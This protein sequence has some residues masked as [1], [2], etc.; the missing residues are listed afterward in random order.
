MSKKTG[1]E[2]A[3]IGVAG[4]FPEAENVSQYWENLIAGK[5]SIRTF[6]PEEAQE[7]GEDISVVN[8]PNY[9]RANAYVD[10]KEFFDSGLFGYLPDEAELM[11]PQVR[12]YHECCWEAL[13]TAGYNPVNT[14]I[15][16][17]IFSAGTPNPRWMI[18]SARENQ[19]QLIDEFTAAHLRD[20]S[21]LSSR[22]AYKLNL[23][24]PAIYLQSACSS[25]LTA[26]HEACSSLLLGE[27]KM[28]L[29]GG[30]SIQSFSKKGYL[31]QE[32]MIQSKDGK[33]RPFDAH[34][35][36]T[37]AGEGVGV[38]VLRRLKDAIE[39]GDTIHAVIKGSAVNNDGSN[40][41][42]YTAP[43][44]K[45]QSEVIS[46][47]LRMAQLKPENIGYVEAH[48]TATELGDPIEVEALNK[49]YG[50]SI[51]ECAL[52]SVKSN[53][54]HLDA[55]AG[56]AGF[57][58]A[59][60]SVKNRTLPATLHFEANNPKVDFA[61]GPFYVNN[62]LQ[63][64]NKEETLRIGVSSFGIGGT[65]AHVIVEE[66]PIQELAKENTGFKNLE[67]SSRTQEGLE[68]LTTNLG[69]FLTKNGSLNLDEVA[70]TLR[71]GRNRFNYRR[72][73]TVAS[74]Q[75]AIKKLQEK[76]YKDHVNTSVQEELKQVAFA[77]SGQGSQYFGM[78][79]DLYNNDSKF[80]ELLDTCFLIAQKY[81]A[82]P[83]QEVLFEDN[84]GKLNETQYTQPLLYIVEF[85][86]AKRL[87]EEGIQPQ[88]L[89]GHSIGEFVAACISGVFS[90]EDGLR[91]VLK[92]GELMASVE[93]GKMLNVELAADK[94][95][96]FLTDLEL[97]I[98][99]I[100]SQKA[101]V[102]AGSAIEIKK[103]TQK[104]EQEGVAHQDVR[105]SHAFHS[106]MMDGILEA[107]KEEVKKVTLNV[108]NI[109][110]ISN[111]SGKFIKPEEAQSPEYWCKHLRS[112]VLFA[113][114]IS[115]LMKQGQMCFI[116]VGPGR[117][118]TN[119]IKANV[120]Y[121]D[122][123]NAVNCVRHP[124]QEV[125]DDYFWAEKMGQLWLYGLNPKQRSHGQKT[126][127]IPLPTYVFEKKEYTTNFN[128]N[129]ILDGSGNSSSWQDNGA[130]SYVNKSG[131]KIAEKP[132]EAD[133]SNASVLVFQSDTTDGA[134]IISYLKA[135][136]AHV[137]SVLQGEQFQKVSDEN[138]EVNFLDD[139]SILEFWNA[140][141]N[142]FREEIKVI[143]LDSSI[144]GDINFESMEEGLNSYLSVANI[145]KSYILSAQNKQVD[146]LVVCHEVVSVL[147]MDQTNPVKA[148]VLG[149]TKVIPSES[150][151]IKIKL[152]DLP[153]EDEKSSVEKYGQQ[154]IDELT[155]SDDVPIVAYRFG[156]KWIQYFEQLEVE[157]EVNSQIEIKENGWYIVTGGF[158][159]MG[160]SIAKDLA[161][162][163]RANLILVHRS[164]FPQED[165]W[166]EYLKENNDK[167]AEKIK[168]LQLIKQSGCEVELHQM[169]VSNEVHVSEFATKATAN[170]VINGL[171]WAAGEP[172]ND[173]ILITRSQPE[174]TKNLKSKVHGVLLFQ[175]HFDFG[176]M[177]FVSLFSSIGNVFYQHKFGQI[178]YNASNEFME[179]Y[180]AYLKKSHSNHVF[181]INWCDWLNVGMTYNIKR[182]QLSGA[183]DDSINATIKGAV[184]PEQGVE[185]FRT[186]L[187]YKPTHWSIHKGDLNQ[188]IEWYKSD[189]KKVHAGE[190][191]SNASE[192]VDFNLE[193]SVLEVIQKF[194]GDT[195][196]SEKDDFFE[197]GGDSLKAMTLV[198]RL[199]K[200][201]NAQLSIKDVYEKPNIGQLVQL[202][203]ENVGSGNQLTKANAAD[204]YPISY[205]Q[206]GLFFLQSLSP[207]SI[208]YN[209]P[210]AFEVG[211]E[212]DF[213]KAEEAF[214]KLLKRHESLRTI[215][216]F[217]DGN[218][219]LQV[220]ESIE[221]ELQKIETNPENRNE[222]INDFIQPFD[223]EQAP[224]FRAGIIS[225]GSSNVLIFDSHHIVMD[226]KSK[227]VLIDEFQRL[228]NGEELPALEFQYKD[229]A[230]W[231]ETILQGEKGDNDKN[232]WLNHFKGFDGQ[233]ELP[234][235]HHRPDVQSDQGAILTL[236]LSEESTYFLRRLASENGTT[237]F[238]VLIGLLGIQLSKY[239]KSEDVVIG[240]PTAGRNDAG[241]EN[242]IGMFVSVLALR[243]APKKAFTFNEYIQEVAATSLECFDHQNYPF[244][245]LVDDLGIERDTKR[246]PLFDVLFVYERISSEQL[247]KNLNWNEVNAFEGLSRNDIAISAVEYDTKIELNLVYAKALFEEDTISRFVSAIDHLIQY[248]E[249]HP[250]A[251]IQD[252]QI[253][254]DEEF[255]MLKYD[256]NATE[257]EII[258]ESIISLFYKQAEKNP[259]QTLFV[260]GNEEVTYGEAIRMIDN[261][262]Y[263][264]SEK[265]GVDHPKVGLLFQASIDML[266]GML[267]V[268][269]AGGLYIP[270]S[271]DFPA[272]RNEYILN[273]SGADV[274][275]VQSHLS[276]YLEENDINF[277]AKKVLVCELET[278]EDV[279]PKN[280]MPT[281]E[282]GAYIIY[283]SG[284][285]GNPKG[286]EVNHLGL[287]NYAQWKSAEHNVQ[288][289]DTTLQFVSYYFDGF[290][291]AYAPSVVSGGAMVLLPEPDK[292]RVDV[293]ADIILRYKV[294]HFSILPAI[295]STLLTE[296]SKLKE[297]ISHLKAVTLA[298]EKANPSL[299]K[300]SKEILPEV[301]I[302]NEYGPTE[303][304][305][306]ITYNSDLEENTSIIGAPI[307]NTKIYI[308]GKDMRI[309]PTGIAGELYVGGKGLSNGYVNNEVLTEEKFIA[310]PF[311][312][313]ERLY[314]TGDLARWLSDGTIEY[315]GR[316]DHQVKLRG[317]R[318]ELGEIESR[319]SEFGSI[320]ESAVLLQRDGDHS[321]LVGYY[322]SEES[323]SDA[324]L[325]AHL[326]SRLPEYMVPSHFMHLT[327][328][329]LTT[330]G[331]LNRKA[332]PGV[333]IETKTE[334]VAPQTAEQE[335]LCSIW[336]SVLNI[337]RVG[338]TDN[339]F[340]I[341]GD[342]IKS[343]QISSRLRDQGYQLS[344]KD[345][346]THQTVV[347]L[348][349]QLE[350]LTRTIDQGTIEGEVSLSPIQ[351]WF[352]D[353]S[354]A[355]KSHFN[356]SVGLHFAEG[357]D[358]E[359]LEFIFT[360]LQTHHDALRM[361]YRS[362]G[363][364]IVQE[365][366]GVEAKLH[367]EEHDVRNS[368][369]EEYQSLVDQL[370]E[371]IDLENGPL[372]RI[373]LF[374]GTS[375]SDVLIVIHHLVIDGVSWRILFEDIQTLYQQHQSGEQAQLPLKT[376][377]FKTWVES[378][379]SYKNEG[380]DQ[381]TV[382]Y[383]NE[384]QNSNVP[385]LPND[386]SEGENTFGNAKKLSFELSQ[387]DTKRLLSNVH[388]A[389]GTQVNDLLLSALA[390]GLKETFG[391]E[392][393]VV[394]LEGHG[395]ENFG[396]NLDV[397]RTVG[398]F[399]SIYPVILNA[400][401][402]DFT[403]VTRQQKEQLR[404]IPKNGFDYLLLRSKEEITPQISF[405][406]LGQF[407]DEVQNDQFSL[408]EQYKGFDI[409]PKANRIYDLDLGG[410]VNQG[411]F[412]MGLSYSPE[413]YEDSRMEVL[414]ASLKRNLIAIMDHCEKQSQPL[415]SP[416]DLTYSS[417]SFESLDALQSEYALE[418]IY[419][420]SPMQEGMLF[421]SLYDNTSRDNFLQMIYSIE[422]AM[423]L[424][425][426]ENSMNRLMDRY[427]VLRTV[428]L[429][430][431]FAE[432]LQM[433]LKDRKVDY[434]YYDVRSEVAQGDEKALLADY[435]ERD[436]N[437]TFDLSKDVMMR[438]TILQTGATSYYFIWSC[439]HILMDGWCM[440]IIIS[441]FNSLYRAYVN[442]REVTLPETQPYATYIEWLSNQDVE[443]SDAFW[444]DY[445]S[446][447]DQLS[448]FPGTD[449]GS[450]D[451]D[452]QFHT[453]ELSEELT[454]SLT[455]YGRE[456]HVT[457]NTL[458]QAAWGVLLSSY[459]GRKDVAF[460][461]VVSGRPSEVAGIEQMVGLFINTVP[462]RV[463]CEGTATLDE[464]LARVQSEALEAEA[465]HSHPLSEIQSHSPLG[466]DL[467]DHIM[468]V[469]NYPVPENDEFENDKG[470]FTADTVDVHEKNQFNLTIFIYPED[471]LKM[472]FVY[473]ASYYSS[474]YIARLSE[475][476]DRIFG[477]FVH[478]SGT[479]LSSLPLVSEEDR[480]SLRAFIDNS[481]AQALSNNSLRAS[482]HQERMWFIDRFE[483]GY[484]YDA[485]PIY[486]NVPLT[487]DFTGSLNVEALQTSLQFV[488]DSYPILRTHLV[489]RE[490]RPY[491]EVLPLELSL[492]VAK[493]EQ[494][495]ERLFID[496][497]F[498]L[499][500]ALIR[501]AVYRKSE[502]NHRFVL[503]I[504]H[505]LVD[506]PSMQMIE[507][508]LLSNYDRL[509]QGKECEAIQGSYSYWD[510]S[511]WQQNAFQDLEFDY[512]N[513]WRD[514][515]GKLKAL[516]IPT[517]RTREAI[518]IYDG[519]EQ[520]FTL[521]ED[522]HAR[523]SSYCE[524]SGLSKEV[525]LMSA[526]KVL[527]YKYA[528]HSEIVIGTSA[529]NRLENE[530]HLLGPVS[531]LVVVK[532][533]LD[534]D[535]TFSRYSEQLSQEYTQDK[536]YHM[537][538]FDKLVKELAPEKDMSRTALFDI[539]YQYEELSCLGYD[540]G[541]LE[542]QVS[543]TNMGYGKYDL[544]LLM[545]SSD[546]ELKGYLVFN[547]DYFDASTISRFVSHYQ[548][549]LSNVLTSP[550]QRLGDIGPLSTEDIAEVH[551][552][553]NHES[554]EYPT[555][556]TLLDLFSEQVA[557]TPDHI[558]LQ[559]N[560]EQLS[561]ADLDRRS[562]AIGA[563]LQDRGVEADTI[564]G[565]LTD[566]TLDTVVCMLGILKAGGAYL[567]IDVDYPEDRKRYI[568]TD[569][570]T[571]FVLTGKEV[572]T[573]VV[574][575]GVQC[576]YIEDIS[577]E[578]S[579]NYTTPEVGPSNLCYIIYTSGT[580]GKPKGVMIEH[581]NVVRLF[582]NESFQFEFGSDDV[583]TM[584]HSHCFDFSV[585]EMYGAL[586]FGGK[587]I[588]VPKW[589][590]RDT[591][592]YVSLLKDEG[593]TVLNQTPSAFYNLIQQEESLSGDLSLRYVIFGGEAL[594]PGKLSE[595]HAVYPSV[596]LI[597]M[598]GITETTVHVTYKK[599]TSEDIERNVSNIGLPIPTLSMYVLDGELNEVPRGVVGEMYIGGRGV[600]RG[601]LNRPELSAE[602]FIES[603][604]VKGERLYKSGDLGRLNSAGEL[605][606]IGRIDHQVQLR[607]F[608]IELGEIENQLSAHDMVDQ[609]AVT[610]Q[611]SEED[612]NLVA[613]YVSDTPIESMTLRSHLL[614]LL[615]DYM[616]PSIY[617]HLD[618]L[619][620]TPNG[621]TDKKAL[622][623][624]QVNTG[625]NHVEAETDIQRTLVEIWSSV[626]SLEPE[627]I[628]I[629]SNF[630]E[631]GG[632]SLN[633]I[634]LKNEI[635]DR[636][637]IEIAIADMFRL[638]TI[639]SIEEFLAG[640]EN[641]IEEMSK[642]IDASQDEA[643]ENLSLITDLFE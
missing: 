1:L 410:I 442:D 20:V 242:V 107:F 225:D 253:I 23:N 500:D 215:F 341:G 379:E 607:G 385:R 246:N 252:L 506:R 466:R 363:G 55:A 482:Y 136:G 177:E 84:S 234:I 367:L 115:E 418:N 520:T 74:I 446:G 491:Q 130:K 5:N 27:C 396:I 121:S 122:Q 348:S 314:R 508:L 526:F 369:S 395:R 61:G 257:N 522:L 241:L 318:I 502:N 621:K 229:F 65:N 568:I 269:R 295:Y 22:M 4:R 264:L 420:L 274:L 489:N 524:A 589:Q 18:H 497:A 620:L 305:V 519:G 358:R 456:R 512:V 304:T 351:E 611:G 330:N 139:S 223:L 285:T 299:I 293:M 207:E 57:I 303:A 604:F 457:L 2:I 521:S 338:I 642:E 434:R 214:R 628:G 630:F 99:V 243:L 557:K 191:N 413:R 641:T 245:M 10:G 484:L 158:G 360:E 159:G 608:R 553:L 235:D 374:H 476:L 138:F 334:Y 157:N 447:Y 537:M 81:T 262:A 433:V 211:H 216:Q 161:M 272:D 302:G 265:A 399:T 566:R 639:A 439:H 104:L 481:G 511:Y 377:A 165:Q 247:E 108:P 151:E 286:V 510:Y 193:E 472:K 98:A 488:I 67:L 180:A 353:G 92:R 70:Y 469:E 7:E 289:G 199:N 88:Y 15:K 564:V 594:S 131:W 548:V 113:D 46:R 593:V 266:I 310:S 300:R 329:P 382:E 95:Q 224:L 435:K 569:S 401:S 551:T 386:F 394:D 40:K 319:L 462:V 609:S 281:V 196:I 629:N 409:S 332:L 35:S 550:D 94:T 432:P 345:I 48:G 152:M 284:T 125:L 129:R 112:T 616:V 496:K 238:N 255:K 24:G 328:L 32:G 91:L 105:T 220:H 178:G 80:K 181:S 101:T 600:A 579:A 536:A 189:L 58:K 146:F 636:L 610:I 127:R 632:H 552:L 208:A 8:A 507:S 638:P 11:D 556:A 473:N 228:Y 464:V 384:V 468:V 31:H 87:M 555:D 546:K 414:I 450:E 443:V 534:N 258:D 203:G 460:G 244:E 325:R 72:T 179:A 261:L 380:I 586:L 143:L 166:S 598:F 538:P 97:D 76:D 383:W 268:H 407:D 298:G 17:G 455:A 402:D 635:K 525:V 387:E 361:V 618:T 582:V 263:R 364:S 188:E 445:L 478:S 390:L 518:H 26:I 356:Q 471:R 277:D 149:A 545:Q 350:K 381:A 619:P 573:S 111:V 419:G 477:L 14:A 79:R 290:K 52:G 162:K 336:E 123:Y 411:V 640:E 503:V 44:V 292:M 278:N 359:T 528:G 156:E 204:F 515:L 403:Q 39:D 430:E 192:D 25:S 322:V 232:F 173:G 599:I 486:H 42:G 109:P 13:E 595:F 59:V 53:I 623:E 339:F 479:P 558:A 222:A 633:L 425:G 176:A 355:P 416:S 291:A 140:T 206:R 504:H 575:E 63:E 275:L 69:E 624:Y 516:E 34:S 580:T 498:A 376:D 155:F 110:Y 85:A 144:G 415:L 475:L 357:I 344:V 514:R 43:S 347:S 172:D 134:S 174:F 567:P 51:Q 103:L 119:N 485:G 606:Y 625:E 544:N 202:T 352:F 41:V 577:E 490:E 279:K 117:S 219:S 312:D 102:V 326:L 480:G 436:L 83:L 431:G 487:I 429:S 210:K 283:T 227:Q 185:V 12:W 287:T 438:L 375:G 622:P 296:F 448:S 184:Y 259:E 408:S 171:I 316:I 60:M 540:F 543:D 501:G 147:D 301:Q 424:E 68:S 309:V 463:R 615:P 6:T 195:T 273:D 276:S 343:I 331:K 493:W 248:L 349:D 637:D 470:K 218:P 560:D 494:T 175:K 163:N 474:S 613:Y 581:G 168:T 66:P 398:W 209:E 426:V 145:S 16:T 412:E 324:E 388:N 315:L 230:V 614:G 317:Y 592:S 33:C 535:K 483:S 321:F 405:N 201:S 527:L 574:P 78:C 400:G 406:Y 404:R 183:S 365:N 236:N 282:D 335:L 627:K 271:K 554:V 499:S 583:W 605:E 21:F 231:E 559:Y 531:N 90:P 371:G 612:K 186:C 597:N 340:S 533:F 561:Y 47:A 141:Q 19:R 342:S 114:G 187:S 437:D 441:E 393:V 142:A 198:A 459:S 182:E 513:Y 54:G 372:L 197:L 45:G 308:L 323:I 427:E 148:T 77:F 465:H 368:S 440:G 154:I 327:E 451:F 634:K 64:W 205:A 133:V 601:Y 423:N 288:K 294:S 37:V 239:L 280:D 585:W 3:V 190:T 213:D 467:F 422:G 570:E 221:F 49:V 454:T 417:L 167:T 492:E 532:S 505:A 509:I 631:I 96:P 337:E 169:D 249:R 250:E 603:P 36:G 563:Y 617:V 120:N 260:C 397:S 346:F 106:R 539:L 333:V 256:F 392:S 164:P 449:L 444:S 116:E 150:K 547:R 132:N 578:L 30:V 458:V 389:Y 124:K 643:D 267:A 391:L 126:R 93:Q 71:E 29:A 240:T 237:M 9:V 313:G 320:T 565:L 118:L 56:V 194:F 362:E 584:F 307:W 461:S 588:I 89:I 212:F 137:I 452:Q 86:L 576:L 153:I 354:I 596:D 217:V 590:S 226:G 251:A 170:R 373:G 50:K 75:D 233:E 160:F 38:V 602:R 529:N 517:D 100:N 73:I 587:L 421:H 495:A 542:A 378:I 370:Q 366:K 82:L 591:S 28:A 306:A 453:L 200:H 530:Q 549:L 572:D 135:S 571:K 128:V 523:L 254:S 62:Q 541:E 297:D 270:I 626:L 311:K 428:F 562:S